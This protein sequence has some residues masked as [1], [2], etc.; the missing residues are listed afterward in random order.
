M[1]LD[2]WRTCT[3]ADRRAYAESIAAKLGGAFAGFVGED[4]LA[5]IAHPEGLE[6]MLIPGGTYERG[7]RADEVAMMRAIDWA[8]PEDALAWL[9][10]IAE[11]PPETVT[12]AA[13]LLARA[14]LLAKDV[15]GGY[16]VGDEESD[17]SAV[18]LD[19]DTA[20]RDAARRRVARADR[21]RVGVGRAR[22]RRAAF[23]D[24][25]TPEDAEA[26]CEDVYDSPYDPGLANGWGVWGL[27]WGDW[28]GD[29]KEPQA[30]R[31]GAAMLYPWQGDELILQLAGLPDDAAGNAEQC[32]R[33]ALDLPT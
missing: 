18:R 15:E 22:G 17:E 29:G 27:P 23:V 20:Q 3:E 8:E 6:L 24:G 12:V 30:G 31:G 26:A 16:V 9:D 14:P 32:L 11:T 2:D 10:Q 25:A 5:V 28:V 1:R 7:V 13:F 21:E 19:R 4:A 33:F